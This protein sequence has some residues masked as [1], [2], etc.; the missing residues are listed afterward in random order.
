MT[1]DQKAS[2]WQEIYELLDDKELSE[3]RKN[4]SEIQAPEHFATKLVAQIRKQKEE[5][6]SFWK[7]SWIPVNLGAFAVVLVIVFFNRAA[8]DKQS[9][10]SNLV[11]SMPS[12]TN[13]SYFLPSKPGYFM[14]SSTDISGI[15]L[16][17]QTPVH[18]DTNDQSLKSN[19][20]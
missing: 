6:R 19:D 16:L 13:V 20:E 11:A 2:Q 4:Y 12:L 10:H 5:K 3:V 8:L 1:D 17:A 14:P 15:S 18:Q 9:A 7:N